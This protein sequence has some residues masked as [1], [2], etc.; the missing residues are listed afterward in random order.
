MK[1]MPLS[2]IVAGLLG[3]AIVFPPILLLYA[4][5]VGYFWLDLY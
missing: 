4:I 3:L 5:Y 1:Y 2:L